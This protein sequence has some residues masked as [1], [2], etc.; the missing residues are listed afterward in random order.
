MYW[1]VDK[2]LGVD[3]LSIFGVE[4]VFF[5]DLVGNIFVV[6]LVGFDG[7]VFDFL[8]IFNGILFIGDVVMG[9]FFGVEDKIDVVRFEFGVEDVDFFCFEDSFRIV[10]D[11]MVVVMFEFFIVGD[12]FSVIDFVVGFCVVVFEFLFFEVIFIIVVVDDVFCVEIVVFILFEIVVED[13]GIFGVIFFLI[14]VF[15]I[16]KLVVCVI[17]CGVD[18]GFEVELFFVVDGD[19]V[20]DERLC[21]FVWDLGFG[22]E[23]YK[24]FVIVEVRDEE[25]MMGVVRLLVVV[26][27]EDFCDEVEDVFCEI[28][29]EMVE[30][31][32]VWVVVFWVVDE[33]IEEDIVVG[34]VVLSN[35][36][37]CGIVVEDIVVLV[38]VCFVDMGVE[39]DEIF[40]GVEVVIFLFIIFGVIILF[41]RLRELIDWVCMRLGF[42]KI[43][44]WFNLDLFRSFWIVFDVL[45]DWFW[46][47]FLIEIGV[48]LLFVVVFEVRVFVFFFII[49]L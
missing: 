5:I 33:E 29:E 14:V 47:I 3:G 23:E 7:V 44:F 22:V 10:V 26:V 12:I 24:V 32:V 45:V 35:D 46:N 16:F 49:V 19:D 13:G 27:V 9:K 34:L 41:I 21:L 30:F 20:D 43:L 18:D 37:F 38:V 2:I 31:L 40:F 1:E 6:V 15:F 36:V 25:L 17:V 28:V 42:I 4:I 11:K 39:F 48:S 8:G